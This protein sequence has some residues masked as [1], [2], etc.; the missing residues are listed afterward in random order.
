MRAHYVH[1]RKALKTMVAHGVV[2]LSLYNDDDDNL[3]ES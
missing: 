1:A 3:S 2:V